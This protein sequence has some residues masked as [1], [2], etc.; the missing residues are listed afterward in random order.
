ME[1]IDFA[2][3][4]LLP[5]W[6]LAGAGDYLCHRVSRI[7]KT[8][9]GVRESLLHLLQW[10]QIALPAGLLVVFGL[11][12]WTIAAAAALVLAHSAT[13]WWDESRT[14]PQRWV[15]T[16]ENHCHAYLIAVPV[17]GVCWAAWLYVAYGTLPA[18][19]PLPTWKI[20]YVVAVFALSGTIIA[21]E[22]LRCRR[23]RCDDADFSQCP[24][25]L[26]ANSKAQPQSWKELP[27]S[28]DLNNNGPADRSRINVNE[29]WELR[30]WTQSLG[31]SEAELRAA[32]QAVGTSASAVRKHLGK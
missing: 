18:P 9:F 2:L 30:W 13:A 21:E 22:W 24:H 25:P 19:T 32:V 31:I 4:G 23:E 15:S 28:D 17:V 26:T 7:A 27:V 29:S 12:H 3:F 6:A 8:P 1:S 16:A 5:L 10:A 14:K 11:R 20:A